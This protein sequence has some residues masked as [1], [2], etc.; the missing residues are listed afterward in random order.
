MIDICNMLLGFTLR[1]HSIQHMVLW[2]PYS[3]SLVN[4]CNLPSQLCSFATISGQMS[5]NCKC[6]ISTEYPMPLH[7][8]GRVTP[9]KYSTC[10]SALKARHKLEQFCAVI[11]F[12]RRAICLNDLLNLSSHKFLFIAITAR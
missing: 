5:Q 1:L 3:D 4:Y 9:L 11:H 2:N 7:L 12:R 10:S 6:G 8:R